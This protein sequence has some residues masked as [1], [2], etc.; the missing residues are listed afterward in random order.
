MNARSQRF[1]D[2]R[3]FRARAF[4]TPSQTARFSRSKSAN[5]YVLGSVFNNQWFGMTCH[6]A[7]ILTRPRQI[8]SRIDGLYMVS[9]S[10]PCLGA[11]EH[12]RPTLLLVH[13]HLDL[14]AFLESAGK[15][16]Q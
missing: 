5:E 16:L 3:C 4:A 15:D 7:H 11:F 1:I 10:C 9:P 2:R 6:L 12:Q 13:I 14:V 8:S